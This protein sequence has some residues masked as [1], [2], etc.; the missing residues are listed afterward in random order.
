MTFKVNQKC[1]IA[2]FFGIVFILSVNT[3]S[4]VSQTNFTTSEISS[5]SVAL[6]NQI[7]TNEKLP[8]SVKVGNQTVNTAQYLHL[9]AQATDQ[10]QNNKSTPITLQNDKVPGYSE[11][12]LNT[13]TMTQADYEDF[14]RRLNE[15]INNNHQAPPYGYI[16]QGKIGYQSQVY[17]FSRILSIYNTTGTLPPYI[18]IKPFTTSNIPILYTAPT[19]FTPS[20]IITAA[21]TLQKTIETT[22]T[23]PNTVTVNGIT[24]YTAQFLHLATTAT[25]QLKNNNKNPILLQNDDQPTYTEEQLNTGTMTQTDYL[26]FATRIT[27]HM[28]QNHQAPPYGYIGLGKISYQSQVYLYTRILSLYNTTGTLPPY[29][30][31]KPFTTSNIPILY[32]APTTFTPSQIITAAVTLQKTIETTKTIPNTVT[33]NG[34]TIYTAQFLHLATTATTQLKNNNK[35]PILLQNDDQPTYTEE[36]LN[37][38]TMTQT[39]YLDFATRITNHMNQNHQAP[40]YGYIGL[41]KISYQS[42]V[43]L[44][45][46][47]L[48]LYNTT[49][50]LPPYITI[51]PFTTSNIPILYTAPTTFTPSQIITA[52]VT[53][54]KTIETTKTIPNTVTVNGITIYTAQFLHLATTATTQLKNNN[55]NPILL[56]NDDQPTYTEEQLNIG[57]MKLADYLDFAQ[58]ITNHMNQNHQA[59]PYG[60]I[61]LGKIS[62][63]SQVYLYTRI[64]SLY[65]STGSLPSSI[66][67][68]P[69]SASNIP[70]LYL[71]SVSFTPLQIVNAAV[72]LKNN[73]ETTK[74]LPNTVIVNGITIYTA[75]F[76]HLAT[77]ATLQ[78]NNKNNNLISL[79]S[80]EQPGYES[81]GLV[82]GVLFQDEYL[83]FAQRIAGHM[84]EN[85]QAP[86]YGYI[87]LGTMGYKSQVY[88]FTRILAYYATSGTLPDN[89]VVKSWSAQ[90]IP[91]NQ[92]NVAF[93]IGQIAITANG[94]K[95]NVEIYRTLP[96]FANVEGLRVNIAQ[97]L[98]LTVKAVVQINNHDTT[99]IPLGKYNIPGY[100]EEQINSGTL[101]LAQYVDFAQRI[102]DYMNENLEAPPYGYIGLG[103]ISF[104]SQ[105]YL[106]SRVMDSY[107]NNGG[108]PSSSDTVKPWLFVIYDIPAGYSQYCLPTLN[109]QSDNPSIIALANNISNSAFSAYDMAARIFNWVRDNTGYE[110]YYNT[111]KG[112]VGTLQSGAGNCVD[113]THLLVAL[114]RAAGLP[115]RYVHANCYFSSGNWYGHVWAMIYVNGQWCW[116]DAT[117]Y[118]NELGVI[119]NW[120]T[121]SY[122]LQGTYTSLP[123]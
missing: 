105:V 53:L 78:L 31:I 123:F 76:L 82:S 35:N 66:D 54:Q 102:M 90:N 95:N 15:Y 44:Y 21:V 80:D 33:V 85:H 41:G 39:D 28:N 51:K 1:I 34:I 111:E 62:Y 81:E 24:I 17:L 122:S 46:R 20:Q 118:R 71:Q 108:L 11:E 98:Y 67:V 9:A 99:A 109:C 69:W 84:N 32:T 58:R 52:A 12:S 23:I 18:T 29:I 114:C 100:R 91:V 113:T 27:N 25:T 13:G 119:N 60:Y 79:Q 38:G 94:V 48:S 75:Q 101:T 37:T 96:E 110:F 2:L 103:K 63:Q 77:L 120:D 10:I 88:L 68:K 55:K 106:Y 115:A 117:S 42:Q 97:F 104:Q 121:G 14:A 26:D 73:I 7:D 74:T 6:Q 87:G 70:I 59:P 83:D 16:G 50:T 107:R 4:A 92:V 30:T 86:P 116:A 93:T 19:T 3:V 49:G 40:P 89:I 45:T 56:Q 43:Y 65:N 47:I 72:T 61:G 64:L 36:Q 22:K 5:A 112:A 57:S 8:D